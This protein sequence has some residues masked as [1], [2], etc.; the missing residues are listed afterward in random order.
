MKN[1]SMYT[2]SLIALLGYLIGSASQMIGEVSKPD[3]F[4][5]KDCLLVSCC[6]VSLS[7][8][9]YIGGFQDGKNK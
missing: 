9:A 4:T 8:I 1:V 2:L 7:L 3:T 5:R 6:L